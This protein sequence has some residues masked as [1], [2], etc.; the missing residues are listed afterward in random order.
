M[1][2]FTSAFRSGPIITTRRGVGRDHDCR[3]LVGHPAPLA[4]HNAAEP[5]PV[6]EDAYLDQIV[7][8]AGGVPDR[9]SRTLEPVDRLRVHATPRVALV[10]VI[11]LDRARLHPLPQV[12]AVDDDA[13]G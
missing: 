11:G 5:D 10:P 6:I 2:Q 7:G 1:S 13:Q 3:C 12:D 9:D 4:W 8:S